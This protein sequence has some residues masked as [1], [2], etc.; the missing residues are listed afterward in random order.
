MESFDEVLAGL[1]ETPK[2]EAK[3]PKRSVAKAAQKAEAT[4]EQRGKRASSEYVQVNGFLRKEYRSSLH[5]YA[6]EDGVAISDLIGR[7]LEEY[8]EKRGGII[9]EPRRR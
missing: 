2:K 4:S 1:D 8:V 9:G 7:L 5:F 6:Q 3:R